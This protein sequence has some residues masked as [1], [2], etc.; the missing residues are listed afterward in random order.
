[1]AVKCVYVTT[2]LLFKKRLLTE[3]LLL[4]SDCHVCCTE[5]KNKI[6]FCRKDGIHR[7]K[8]CAIEDTSQKIDK[9][10]EAHGIKFKL[11]T[12]A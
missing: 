8:H 2:T 9:S 12:L 6:K 1:M 7:I 4:V 10:T 5:L 11:L 3:V